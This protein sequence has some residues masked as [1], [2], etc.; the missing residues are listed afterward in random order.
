[1]YQ[2]SQCGGGYCSGGGSQLEYIASSP[3]YSGN[4]THQY[5]SSGNTFYSTS[6]PMHDDM[7][8]P[9]PIYSSSTE[10][11]TSQ[12]YDPNHNYNIIKVEQN[13]HFHPESFLKPG[14][15]SKFVGE[16]ED[17]QEYVEE[18]FE[19]MFDKPFPDNIKVS[20]VNKKKFSKLTTSP[21]TI[22]L[23]INRMNQ[24]LL[25]EIFILNDSLARVMLTIGHELGHVLTETLDNPHDEE[26]KA[27]AFSL[28]WMRIIKENDIANL[29]EAIITE[30]PADN[31]L[32]NVAFNFVHKLVQTGKNVWDVYL[33]LVNKLLNVDLDQF[34][35]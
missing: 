11:L 10:F 5:S 30:N 31:G 27:Y 6:S 19:K 3:S 4:D 15:G 33:G 13:Y 1:M 7:F 17:V 21:G 16:A 34:S 35:F 25:S 20:V 2:T 24:G 32:H 12:V 14:K 8:V 23:S 22:G 29:G 26:A 28:E 18:A 9:A